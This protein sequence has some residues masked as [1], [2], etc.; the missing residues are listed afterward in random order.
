MP[1]QNIGVKSSNSFVNWRL[2]A[3]QEALKFFSQAKLP[4]AGC[5]REALSNEPQTRTWLVLC[6]G[7]CSGIFLQL[8][9]VRGSG[10]S[11]KWQESFQA[12]FAC[13]LGCFYVAWLLPAVGSKELRVISLLVLI[14]F[15]DGLSCCS[16]LSL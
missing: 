2:V 7:R 11:P 13:P 10:T 15:R 5:Q 8:R 1:G 4:S 9:G 3:C 12:D 6:A 14:Y 16:H